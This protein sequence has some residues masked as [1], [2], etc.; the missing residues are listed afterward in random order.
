MAHCSI[1][2]VEKVDKTDPAKDEV[3][4]KNSVEPKET[5]DISVN[6]FLWIHFFKKHLIDMSIF[7]GLWY[8]CFGLLLMSPLIFK[9]EVDS[10]IH[11]WQ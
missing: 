8:P 11:T 5:F 10:L 2:E 7:G 4:L 9:A 6:D 1:D 3:S